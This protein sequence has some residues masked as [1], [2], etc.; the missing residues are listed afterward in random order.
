MTFVRRLTRAAVGSAPLLL[1]VGLAVPAAHAD[2]ALPYTDARAQ[3]TIGLCDSAG[4]PV[5]AGNVAD[6][7]FV[8]TVVSSQPA[9]AKYSVRSGKATLYAFQPR[10]EVDPG[11]WSGQQLSGASLFTNSKHPM[12][13]ITTGDKV[14]SDFLFA[15]PAKW[16]GLVQLRLYLS[17]PDQP[18]YTLRYPT[19][20]LKVTGNTWAVV[21][22]V[23]DV[24]CTVGK[25]VSVETLLLKPSSF[26]S[27]S[28]SGERPSTSATPVGTTTATSPGSTALA[29]GSAQPVSAGS[30]GSPATTILLGLLAVALVIAIAGGVLYL[31]GRSAARSEAGVPAP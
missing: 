30:S 2:P 17:A 11:E 20:N 31:R 19:V 10:K 13:A 22:P 1:A 8:S 12:A 25:A 24:S 5:T 6:L 4:H 27:P 14:L 21:G 15:F 16:D 23:S 9:P 3:G 26:P 18:Q 7:P 28:Q 29:G